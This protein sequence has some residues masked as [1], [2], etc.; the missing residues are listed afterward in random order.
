L[1]LDNDNN[2]KIAVAKG[3]SSEDIKEFSIKLEEHYGWFN[4]G[5]HIIKT[6]IFNDIDGM[7]TINMLET[8]E[9]IKIKSSISSP[10]IIAGQLYGFLNIDS[11]YSNI[12]TEGDLELMEYMRNQVS[13]AI[14]K[15]KLN[16]QFLYLS[17][18]DKL[19]NVYN[20]S[21][22]EQLIYDNIYNDNADKKDFLTVVFDLNDL[23]FVNDNYGH[24][25]GDELIRTFSQYLISLTEDSDIIGRY[26]G[27]EF[28]G[29]FFN[30]DY[31]SLIT[32]FEG[33]IEKFKNNPIIFDGN[34]IVCSYSY[35]IVSCPSEGWEFDKAIKI[36]DKRM[37]E[38]KSMVKSKEHR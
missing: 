19:S 32:R 35:G 8:E 31:Q 1:I 5:K 9:G 11:E 3:Y 18:Y 13:I 4:S 26:G 27:D 20:R 24:L 36:A 21:Y 15:H 14:E 38:Y 22:F 17:R 6:V 16:E 37:Y 34:E 12:F 30:V 2:L 29:V 23:K 10:I 28:I 25:A 7:K 33:L